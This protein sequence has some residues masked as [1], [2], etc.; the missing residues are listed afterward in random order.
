MYDLQKGFDETDCLR[1]KYNNSIPLNN[2]ITLGRFT[3]ELA[4]KNQLEPDILDIQK[5]GLKIRKG[6]TRMIGGTISSL[7]G[8]AAGLLIAKKH[9]KLG[10]PIVVV[11]GALGLTLTLSGLAIISSGGSLL[12]YYG[13][14]IYRDGRFKRNYPF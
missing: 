5:A 11:T 12:E 4:L 6:A 7:V 13:E 1:D 10:Y 3:Q 9:P 14:E 8:P 2:P